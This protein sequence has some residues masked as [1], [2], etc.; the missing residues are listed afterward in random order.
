[1]VFQ[2]SGYTFWKLLFLGGPTIEVSWLLHIAIE[3]V[4]IERSPYDQGYDRP[5]ES[6]VLNEPGR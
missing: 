3:Q 1:M 6:R 4:S 2:V 5:V